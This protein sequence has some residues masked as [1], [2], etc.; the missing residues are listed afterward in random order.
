M[1]IIDGMASHTDRLKMLEYVQS[2]DT[3]PNLQSCIQYAQQ[4]ELIWKFNSIEV[5]PICTPIAHVNKDGT[6]KNKHRNMD[7]ACKFCGTIHRR[8]S[9]PAYG[10]TCQKCSKRNHF[11]KVCRSVQ[12]I[13]AEDAQIDNHNVAPV[14]AVGVN[15]A[16]GGTKQSFSKLK[17]AGV[18]LDMQLDS[19]SEATIIP[20]NFWVKLGEPKLTRTK[21]RL[22]QFDGTEIKTA[23]EFQACVELRDC[24]TMTNV[25]VAEC[26][27]HHGLVGTNVLQ[28]DFEAMHVNN[29]SNKHVHANYV[30]RPVGCLK[31]FKASIILKENVQ[32]IFFN[33]R[34]LP[35]HI[36]PLVVQRLKGMLAEGILERVPPGGSAW[37]SPLVVV[38][39]ADGGIR[40]CADYKVGVNQK[41]CSESYPMPRIESALT[42]LANMKFFAK[43]DL[44]SAYHQ[45]ELDEVS[46]E[47][48]TI[49]TPLGL[50]RWTRL[51]FGIKTASALFQAAI[52]KT[53]LAGDSISN[54]VVYQD[55]ICIG[56]ANE[57]ELN[58]K[59]SCVL[60]N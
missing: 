51:P 6:I 25:V 28:I 22:H 40:I 39:K 23:G 48:T 37:A 60:K 12:A 45:I 10:K 55:D 16:E 36:K 30:A 42:S 15:T 50:L 8:G 59:V 49:N 32:P 41:I 19:G 54:I 33:A 57:A 20:K 9:C 21:S 1:R 27:K 52:E 34:P 26:H 58:G 11:A 17:I 43:I 18:E 24:F 14:F 44:A 2:C 31:N 56:A 3:E 53:V 46:R 29:L 35:V 7:Q 5:K 4:L 38:H 47:I 13:V